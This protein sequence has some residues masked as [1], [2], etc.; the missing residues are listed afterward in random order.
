[1]NF[2]KEM[3]E[4][5]QFDNTNDLHLDCARFVFG[6]ILNRELAAFKDYWNSH[7]IKRNASTDP[8][9]RPHGRPD[10]LY[11][12]P[13]LRTNGQIQDYKSQFDDADME[14][15]IQETCYMGPINSYYCSLS[16]ILVK[17]YC[18]FSEIPYYMKINMEVFNSFEINTE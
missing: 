5:N 6:P 18:I 15:A 13:N 10:V 2:F 9:I 7:Y 12:T 14:I 4:L 11:F 17:K 16:Y 8:N 3:L 1:M